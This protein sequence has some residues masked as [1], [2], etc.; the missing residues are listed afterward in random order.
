MEDTNWGM[1]TLTDVLENLRVAENGGD[2]T[3]M[4]VVEVTINE[5]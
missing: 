5:G 2:V 4:G 1:S 3:E